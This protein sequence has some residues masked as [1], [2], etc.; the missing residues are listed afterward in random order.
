MSN[1]KQVNRQAVRSRRMLQEALVELLREKPY[2]KISITD[3]TERADLARPTF[4]AHFDTKDDLLLSYVDDIFDQLF[5]ELQSH[6]AR[7]FPDSS[8]DIE[9]N[10]RLFRLWQENGE[11]LRLIRTANIDALI[12]NRLREYH[13]KTYYQVIAPKMP[14]LNPVLAGYFIDFLASTTMG[15][16]WHWVDEKMG[17]PSEVMGKFLYALT[18]PPVLQKVVKEFKDSVVP[19]R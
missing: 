10:A 4:Y 9:M 19:A 12:L 1:K 13:L 11:I 14:Q 6:A 7:A 3:I 5:S 18:G 16:L 17:Q 2:Q 8:T 15:L